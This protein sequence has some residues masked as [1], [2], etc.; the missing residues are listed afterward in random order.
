MGWRGSN[1][2]MTGCLSPIAQKHCEFIAQD[3]DTGH[4]IAVEAKSRRQEGVLQAGS[5]DMEQSVRGDVD[6]LI[7][8]A[9]NQNPGNCAFMIFVD[10]NA[11]PIRA[12]EG[13]ETPW[14]KDIRALFESFET[15]TADNPSLILTN[16]SYHWDQANTGGRWETMQYVSHHPKYPLPLELLA[17]ISEAVRTYGLV[18][19]EN[20]TGREGENHFF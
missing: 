15:A 6:H 12:I 20:L 4:E 2:V 13:P 9:L 1:M 3:Q 14:V 8:D 19:R 5:L 18:P 10:V 11:C 7:N 17:R 16:G